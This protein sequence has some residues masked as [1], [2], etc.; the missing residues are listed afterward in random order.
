METWQKT[1]AAVGVGAG[2]LAVAY[3]LLRDEP[4]TGAEPQ[5][6]DGK[7]KLAKD[8]TK[9]QLI[10]MMR[11]IVEVQERIKARMKVVTQELLQSK[12]SFEETYA[13]IKSVNSDDVLEKYG[14][15]MQEFDLLLQKHQQD[16]EVAQ[17]IMKIM[18]VNEGPGSKKAQ[19]VTVEQIVNA[20]KLM[21]EELLSVHS[22]IE[23]KK[24]DLDVKVVSLTCQAIISAKVEEKFGLT[25]EDMEGAV[26]KLHE[27]LATNKEFTDVSM[28][29]QETLAK[30]MGAPPQ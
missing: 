17:G 3:Y 22:L 5:K 6:P 23:G 1:L 26:A 15:P 13:K 9:E 7:K 28:R 19:A 16:P 11:E 24:D 25:S 18:G 27:Q 21:L 2:A 12:H 4:E 14:I 8:V 20:H 10:Q 30:L 29:M